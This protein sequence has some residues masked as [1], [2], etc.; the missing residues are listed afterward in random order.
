MILGY[1]M[2]NKL[3][4]LK[5]SRE[6]KGYD[7]GEDDFFRGTRIEK[8]DFGDYSLEGLTHLIFIERKASTSELSQNICEERFKKLL[9]RARQYK[10]KYILCEFDYED[11]L[12]FPLNSGIPKWQYKKLKVKPAFMNAFISRLSVEGFQIIFAGNALNAEK[13]C[14]SILKYIYKQ[15]VLNV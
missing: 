15:E 11:I 3:L 10:Y 1:I 7:W 13:F 5:D 14:Y 4:I 6:Q 8:I 12:N 2:P 9:I